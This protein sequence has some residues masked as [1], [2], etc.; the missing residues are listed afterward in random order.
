MGTS[1]HEK[2]RIDILTLYSEKDPMLLKIKWPLSQIDLSIRV[3][4]SEMGHTLLR[5]HNESLFASTVTN[6]VWM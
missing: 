6:E 4:T 2:Q 5:K 3:V 1:I